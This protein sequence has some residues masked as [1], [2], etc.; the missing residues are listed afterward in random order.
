M[1]NHRNLL[2][3][4][5]DEASAERAVRDI[6]KRD[7]PAMEDLYAWFPEKLMASAR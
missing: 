1:L 5:Y 6:G 7:L 4:T 3:H 2:S